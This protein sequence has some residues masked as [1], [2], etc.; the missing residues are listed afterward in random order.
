MHDMV[1]QAPNEP[2]SAATPRAGLRRDKHQAITQAARIVFGRNGYTRTS[3]DMIAAEAD[4]STRTL[5]KHFP[6]KE[7][8]FTAVLLASATHVAE[9]FSADVER[10]L[11]GVDPLAD[12]VALGYACASLRT[13]FADHFAMVRWIEAEAPH[14]PPATIA[15]WQQA[16]PL[17]VQHEL[18]RRL[19]ELGAQG[20]LRITDPSQ[21]AL[22][23]SA[24][25][26]IGL[27]AYYGAASLSEEQVNGAVIAGVNAFLNGYAAARPTQ[28]GG[29]S[30]DT[31]ES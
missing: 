5:Y 13:A 29:A 15:A 10:Q 3:M 25:V 21:A 22:H 7:H 8:L 19:H 30:Y 12:L 6:S 4:V 1:A 20:L 26:T 31:K 23:F 27:T 16:G 28:A 17:R 11:S 18:A 24:L 2:E 14:F 9:G